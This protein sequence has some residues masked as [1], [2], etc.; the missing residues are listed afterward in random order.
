M[1]AQLPPTMHTPGP[2][3]PLGTPRR[4]RFTGLTAVFGLLA[5]VALLIG[6]NLGLE[7]VHRND[8]ISEHERLGKEAAAAL[9]SFEYDAQG[10]VPRKLLAKHTS[11]VARVKAEAT[12][13][14]TATEMRNEEQAIFGGAMLAA[15]ALAGLA[16]R[17]TKPSSTLG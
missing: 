7:L 14:Q 2:V 4:R 16:F 1:N 6:A 10:N 13:V 17:S 15:L 5:V 12:G 3:A 11:L 9:E 8:V